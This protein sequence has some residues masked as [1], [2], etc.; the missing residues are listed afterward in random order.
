MLYYDRIDT[1]NGTDS[2]KSHRST[3]MHD[4]LLL[5]FK[6]WIQISQLY[7]QWLP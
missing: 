7:L 5:V 2:T 3:K 6:C 4:L 1:N